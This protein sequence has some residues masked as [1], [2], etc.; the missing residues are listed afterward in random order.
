MITRNIVIMNNANTLMSTF[1]IF[2]LL[3]RLYIFCSTITRT[4][5][6]SIKSTI[7][8]S[9]YKCFK[10]CRGVIYVQSRVRI[11]HGTPKPLTHS[12]CCSTRRSRSCFL[13]CRPPGKCTDAL[14]S[15]WGRRT[16][17]ASYNGSHVA[18]AAK[19]AAQIRAQTR[20]RHPYPAL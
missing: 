10:A 1:I 13:C 9:T 12:C 18:I 16:S 5:R 11:V 3:L 2:L 6:T 15:C 7:V 4:N 19:A 8:H 14:H 20:R 17:A